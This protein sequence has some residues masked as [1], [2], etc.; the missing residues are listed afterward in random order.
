MRPE[1]KT[2]HAD[3]GQQQFTQLTNRVFELDY[4]NVCVNI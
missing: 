4:R 1:T 2:G 3:E